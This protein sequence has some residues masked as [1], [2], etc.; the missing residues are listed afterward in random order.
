[1][2][3]HPAN[4]LPEIRGDSPLQLNCLRGSLNVINWMT[5]MPIDDIR[6]THQWAELEVLIRQERLGCRNFDSRLQNVGGLTFQFE[7]GPRNCVLTA[8]KVSTA[9]RSE[10]IQVHELYDPEILRK[11]NVR[12]EPCKLQFAFSVSPSDLTRASAPLPLV[13]MAR[14]VTPAMVRQCCDEIRIGDG[15]ISGLEPWD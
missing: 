8:T 1:M 3:I 13:P 14:E 6:R 9:G 12:R 7:W 15:Q 5:G 2:H 11:Q 10:V 4:P